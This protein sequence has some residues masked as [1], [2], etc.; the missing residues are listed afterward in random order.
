MATTKYTKN[1]YHD[2]LFAG[3]VLGN[4]MGLRGGYKYVSQFKL[5]P[6][7]V[8]RRLPGIRMCNPTHLVESTDAISRT[9]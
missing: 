2:L 3:C 5:I 4:M 8:V 9:D 7:P 1:M 6:F